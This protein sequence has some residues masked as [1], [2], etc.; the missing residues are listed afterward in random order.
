MVGQFVS[1]LDFLSNFFFLPAPFHR[2]CDDLGKTGR[3]GDAR[4][5]IVRETLVKASGLH[6]KQKRR[7]LSFNMNQKATKLHVGVSPRKKKQSGTD[8]KREGR[9][10][11]AK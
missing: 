8:R 1:R 2:L 10:A 7:Y 9:E 5:R 4:K 3:L 11:G 6:L